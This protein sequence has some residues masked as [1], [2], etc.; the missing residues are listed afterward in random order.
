M[1]ENNH[2]SILYK[3]AEKQ[4]LNLTGYTP[5]SGGD[6]NDVFLLETTSENF[7]IKLNDASSYPGMFE[8]E[9]AGLEI[10]RAPKVIDIPNPIAIGDID[11]L[12]FLLLEYKPSGKQSSKFWEIFGEQL[13]GLHQ[14]TA[15]SFGLDHSNYIGSLPQYNS[16][17]G[18]AADFYL[19][20]RLEPQI[21]LA[22]D[23]GFN[24]RIPESFFTNCSQQIPDEPPALLHGD[25]WNGN[26]LINSEGL[27]CLIDPAVAYAPR[28]MDIAMMHLFR[29]FNDKLFRSYHEIYPL[30]SGWKDRLDLWQLYYLLV[31]LNLFG[32]PYLSRCTA[33]LDKYS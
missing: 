11:G 15:A 10:L 31:H 28:E 12:S 13:A 29:G 16:K 23:K 18:S 33:I 8:A 30:E 3:I 21:K 25:L 1:N 20:M 14:Q 24:F 2:K 4:H 32:S 27:P 26:Y 9:K 7:V 17:R 5:L 6:I 22:R 19:E